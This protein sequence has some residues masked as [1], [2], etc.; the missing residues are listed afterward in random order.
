MDASKLIEEL[1]ELVYENGDLPV[2]VA[3]GPR[4]FS[5]KDAEHGEEGSLDDLQQQSPP[6]RI[7]LG[8]KDD[9]L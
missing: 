2:T 6:E 7:V 8:A 1:K 3:V 5:V 4:E 9:I